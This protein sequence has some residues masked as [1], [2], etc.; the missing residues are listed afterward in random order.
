MVGR[1]IATLTAGALWC[2]AQPG[3]KVFIANQ[4]VSAKGG[5]VTISALIKNAME[6][7]ANVEI[8]TEILDG[9][10]V[11]GRAKASANVGPFTSHQVEA[12]ARVPNPKEWSFDRPQVYRARTVLY[13]HEE[14][15]E[16]AYTTELTTAFAFKS[17][18]YEDAGSVRALSPVT[19]AQRELL[20]DGNMLVVRAAPAAWT[21]EFLEWADEHGVLVVKDN[22]LDGPVLSDLVD[23]EGRPRATFYKLREQ[24]C[25]VALKDVYQRDGN[26]YIDLE[27]RGRTMRDIEVRV[28]HRTAK[29]PLLKRGDVVTLEF[30]FQNPFRIEVTDAM[31]ALIADR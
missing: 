20:R 25:P 7:T 31:G 1:L 10:N 5:E 8:A 15:V 29:V 21:Q 9:V 14:A 30:Q 6:N 17:L 2:A 13:K 4:S 11:V 28:G 12:T 24:L 19:K 18:T 23:K 27:G 26:T 16:G 3:H 22:G